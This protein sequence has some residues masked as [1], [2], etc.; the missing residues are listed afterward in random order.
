MQP[1]ILSHRYGIGSVIKILLSAGKTHIL[2]QG[3]SSKLV[4]TLRKLF[5]QTEMLVIHKIELGK[6]F[7]HV[8]NVFVDDDFL[9]LCYKREDDFNNWVDVRNT[10]TGQLFHS[11]SIELPQRSFPSFRNL[12]SV[13]YYRGKLVVFCKNPQS[14]R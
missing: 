14:F 5:S 4:L 11:F 3:R 13:N 7:T 9:V 2:F 6:L 1:K 12:I 10:E 8:Y